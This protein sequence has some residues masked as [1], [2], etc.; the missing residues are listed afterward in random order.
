MSETLV[1]K[2]TNPRLAVIRGRLVSNRLSSSIRT[3]VQ[4]ERVHWRNGYLWRTGSARS[5]EQSG[6][7]RAYRTAAI[8]LS[9]G[10]VLGG[11]I[12]V[13]LQRVLS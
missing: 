10:S 11:A 4:P 6:W 3:D 13:I 7:G 1:G 8:G 9:A 2:D 12:L 5:M